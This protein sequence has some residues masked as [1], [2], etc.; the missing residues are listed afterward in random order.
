VRIAIRQFPR[1]GLAVTNVDLAA[2]CHGFLSAHLIA[3]AA[4]WFHWILRSEHDDDRDWPGRFRPVHFG[5][6]GQ[7]R[8][9]YPC[10]R[11]PVGEMADKIHRH[12][13]SIASTNDINPPG[14]RNPL[15]N[16]SVKHLTKE[17]D[18]IRV[19]RSSSD[20]VHVMAAN[21]P[22]IDPAGINGDVAFAGPELCEVGLP[23]H[24][25]ST[26]GSAAMQDE[27]HRS[28]G[29]THTLRNVNEE[30]SFRLAHREGATLQCCRDCALL[31]PLPQWPNRPILAEVGPPTVVLTKK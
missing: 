21:V 5:C 29:A 26:A 12:H 3:I 20:R 17:P 15:F 2:D 7:C 25:Q 10:S 18:I 23:V 14:V 8:D 9:Q 19:T 6:A 13:S 4:P 27:H 24:R 22:S 1:V 11:D 31:A 28:R 30:L 16:Q